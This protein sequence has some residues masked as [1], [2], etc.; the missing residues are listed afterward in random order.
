MRASPAFQVSLQQFAFWRTGV[1]LLAL[2][3]SA[4]TLAWCASGTELKPGWVWLLAILLTLALVFGGFLAARTPSMRLRWDT[5][6]WRLGPAVTAGEEPWSGELAVVIDFGAWMLL[7]FRH[8][9]S[10]Q[11]PG[12]LTSQI[13]LSV[14]RGGGAA[15]WHALRCAVYSS[16]PAQLGLA[17]DHPTLIE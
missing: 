12:L 9:H 5:Q 1:A 2:M 15:S 17:T 4:S 8:T 10:M 13:W 11:R 16:R 7:R 6:S 14:Q 3:A